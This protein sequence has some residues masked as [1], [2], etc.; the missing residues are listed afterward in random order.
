MNPLVLPIQA[1]QQPPVVG[2][3]CAVLFVALTVHCEDSNPTNILPDQKLHLQ[4]VSLNPREISIGRDTQCVVTCR[5]NKRA[6]VKLS[7]VD[8]DG[9]VVANR[10]EVLNAGTQSI[11]WNLKIGKDD[12]SELSDGLYTYVLTATDDDGQSVT[13]EPNMDTAFNRLDVDK[14]T[15][16]FKTGSLEYVMPQLGVTRIRLFR[17]ENM[18]VRTLQNW[19]PQLAGRYKVPIEGKDQSGNAISL[20]DPNLTCRITAYS[21]PENAF[22]VS[23]SGRTK[24]PRTLAEQ[25]RWRQNPIF[26]KKFYH[27]GIPREQSMDANLELKFLSD[28]GTHEVPARIKGVSKLRVTADAA[29]AVSLTDERFEICVYVDGVMLFEDEDGVLPYTF[30]Q[31]EKGL[32]AGKHFITVWLIST[33]DHMGVVTVPVD[34]GPTK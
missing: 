27:A 30:E 2:L 17:G 31:S 28:D 4:P 13:Y 7:I 3:I 26:A 21:L 34:V 29:K 20:D 1:R 25:L 9:E 12:K 6:T 16:D 5:I 18:L 33:A 23:G 24:A 19:T 14:A 8:W 15:A 22:I 11:N 10:V 32:S